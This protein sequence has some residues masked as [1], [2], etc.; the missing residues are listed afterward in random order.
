MTPHRNR[1]RTYWYR[2]PRGLPN[3]YDVGIARNPTA[4]AEYERRGYTRI[5]RQK[6]IARIS[7]KG[8]TATQAFN[9]VSID[10]DENIDPHDI[11]VDL[12]GH[13]TV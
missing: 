9:T 10:A 8:D 6:A 5:T 1:Y 3:E 2:C 4:A 12:L 13:T 7:Y 11:V